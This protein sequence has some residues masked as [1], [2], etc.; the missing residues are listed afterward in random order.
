MAPIDLSLDLSA[1]KSEDVDTLPVPVPSVEEARLI[2]NF[3]KRN[4]AAQAKYPSIR[5]LPHLLYEGTVKLPGK[6][7]SSFPF[8]FFIFIRIF[9]LFF[10]CSLLPGFANLIVSTSAAPK[11]Y[12]KLA[13]LVALPSRSGHPILPELGYALPCEVQGRFTSKYRPSVEKS[14]F[15]ERREEAKTLLDEYDQSMRNLGK[16]QPKYTEYPRKL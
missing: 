15:D 4:K 11:S 6:A 1:K 16:R 8:S 12:D 13:P 7:L 9:S 10:A 3:K 14:G 5:G 2:A